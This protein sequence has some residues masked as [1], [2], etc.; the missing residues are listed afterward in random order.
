MRTRHIV[1]VAAVMSLV[2][3]APLAAQQL[4]RIARERALAMLDDV[5]RDIQRHYYD[6][7]FRGIDLSRTF[8]QA[9]SGIRRANSTA[10]ALVAIAQATLA[11][12]DSHTF[13][14]PPGLTV[15]V[16][17]GW[18]AR[19]VGDSCLV[20]SVTKGSDAEKQGLAPGDAIVAINGHEPTRRTL[21]LLMY[22]FHWIHPQRGLHVATSTRELDLAATVRQR[23]KIIDLTGMDGGGDLWRLIN[24]EEDDARRW[25]S[26]YYEVGDA[27]VWRLPTFETDADVVRQMMGRARKKSTLVLDLRGDGGGLESTMLA[28]L[29]ELFDHDVVIGTLRQRT[30]ERPLVAKS[31]GRQPYTGKLVVLIDSRSA[32]ASEI[33]ARTVQLQHRGI[34]M[35][36]RSA[37]MVM[38]SMGYPHAQGAE[39]QF[40]YTTSVTD[41]DILMSDG[42]RI[43]GMGVIPNVMVLPSSAD[44]RAHRD[45]VLA[46]ALGQ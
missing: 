25:R 26:E 12:N 28:L 24:D 45:P 2:A 36:D 11:L 1:H 18:S 7:T 15:Q 27:L 4:D 17:Y 3:A 34:V 43:E 32:S 39:T 20:D 9:D 10:D 5:H 21:L 42:A 40:W 16:D 41:A 31:L 6:S 29:G 30:G 13:F 19:M 33:V 46:R 23:Q 14:V 44:L 38:R 8:A 22:G 35:G 37:G